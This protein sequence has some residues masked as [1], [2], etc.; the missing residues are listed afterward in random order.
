MKHFLLLLFTFCSSSLLA[1]I[2]LIYV[3]PNTFPDKDNLISELKSDKKNLKLN[4]VIS[5]ISNDRRPLIGKNL[6][7][8]NQNLNA[9]SELKSGAPTT[10]FEVDTLNSIFDNY[11]LKNELF[12]LHFYTDYSTSVNSVVPNLLNRFLLCNDLMD[13][14]GVRNNVKIV[15]HIKKEKNQNVEQIQKYFNNLNY[16]VKFL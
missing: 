13:I 16:E 5:F 15:F 4:T 11:D 14:N 3:T 2:G 1:Q 12:I 7:D 9:I 8:F 6:E 10:F